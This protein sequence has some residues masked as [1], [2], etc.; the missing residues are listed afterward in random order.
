MLAMTT[1]AEGAKMGEFKTITENY[2]NADS[3]SVWLPIQTRG[4]GKNEMHRSR[5][6]VCAKVSQALSRSGY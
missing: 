5:D 6:E 2:R 3:H 4:Q 1:M